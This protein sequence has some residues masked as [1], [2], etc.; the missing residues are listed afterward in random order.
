MFYFRTK[1]IIHKINV[2]LGYKMMNFDEL[3]PLPAYLSP[4]LNH[5]FF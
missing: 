4:N 2:P 5:Y 1:K 3:I